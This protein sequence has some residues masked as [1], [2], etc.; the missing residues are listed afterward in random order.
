MQD[1]NWQII[2][3][4]TID[5]VKWNHCINQSIQP[6]IYAQSFYLN[7]LCANWLA[8][9]YKDYEAVIPVPFKKKWSFQYCY[10]P[11]FKQQ[12]GLFAANIN[13]DLLK[14][15]NHV[16]KHF[17]YGDLYIPHPQL[18]KE[19]KKC[20][21]I[22]KDTFE[23]NL[24]NGYSFIQQNYSGDLI[25][26][27]EKAQKHNLVLAE[28]LHPQVV[29]E[30]FYRLYGYTMNLSRQHTNTFLQLLLNTEMQNKFWVLGVHNTNQRLVTGGIFLMHESSVYNIIHF[31]NEEGRKQSAG[32]FL[33]DQCI[34]KV[35]GNS[36]IFDFE[37]S[38]LPGVQSFYKNFHPKH[39]PYWHIHINQLP[40]PLRWLKQ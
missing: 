7:A 5:E 17:N 13:E 8:F 11:P 35:A 25:L 14:G 3:A 23:L 24:H 16:I 2:P 20:K 29:L 1:S 4:C 39:S 31:V 6:S 40:I 27:L 32:H 30:A 38:S 15:I 37:G 34:R 36:I 10:Q 12:L 19:L 21:A 28:D 18:P 26:N 22:L 33:I 9:V